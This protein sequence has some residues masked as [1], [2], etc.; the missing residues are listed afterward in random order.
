MKQITTIILF[1]A[2]VLISS[3]NKDEPKFSSSEIQRA[4]FEMKGTYHGEMRVSYYHG[5]TISEGNTCKV[6]SKDFLTGNMDLSLMALSITDERIASRL[7]DIGMIQV[8]AAY[9]FYQ[10]DEQMYHFV[11]LPK[12]VICLGRYDVPETVKIVFDQNFGGGADYFHHSI[13]F[14][15]SPKELWFGDKKYEP[16]QQL[17]YHFEGTYE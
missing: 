9:E 14:N 7:R 16:F 5:N 3:C 4:L 8:K 15:L 2:L 10:M 17:V 11:L 12:N 13:V 1:I 6:V